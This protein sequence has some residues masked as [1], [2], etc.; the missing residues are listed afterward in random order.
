MADAQAQRS[1]V[2]TGP[3]RSI[4]ATLADLQRRIEIV[5]QKE[6]KVVMFTGIFKSVLAL[7]SIVLG[8]FL[9][10]WVFDLPYFARLFSV[11][12]GVGGISYVVNKHLLRELKK[13]RDD[14]EIA[15]RIEG[16]N[17]DLRGRLISTLQLAR[18]EKHGKYVG[19]PELLEALEDETIKMS[20]PL[21][22]SGIINTD[23][24]KRM[25]VAA[26][27]VLIVKAVLL[28]KFPDYFAALGSRLV[29]ADG[30]FPTKTRIAKIVK[31]QYVARGDDLVVTVELDKE[32]SNEPSDDGTLHF[33]GADNGSKVS[34]AMSR[35]GDKIYS[36][37]L[38][39]P[40]ETMSFVVAIG[41]TRSKSETV[42]VRARPEIDVQKS[43]IQYTLPAYTRAEVPPVDKFGSI[44]VLVGSTA[45]VSIASTKALTSAKIHRADGRDYPLNKL[46]DAGLVWGV[47]NFP[48]DKSNSFHV[49]LVGTD[50]LQNSQPAIEYPIDARPDQ[51]PTIRM[52]KP[53]RDM[54]VIKTAKRSIVFSARDDFNVRT[55]WLC[56]QIT[57]PQLEGQ[58]MSVKPSDIKRYEIPNVPQGKDIREAK[59]TWDL[60][61]LNLNIGETVDFWIEA[62][63]DC[64]SNDFEPVRRNDAEAVAPQAK[65]YPR[66]TDVKLT[67]VTN[68]E[69][70]QEWLAE[71][72]RLSNEIGT[73]KS[74]QEKVGQETIDMLENYEK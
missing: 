50:G 47:D 51:A 73:A 26:A 59:F 66:S 55:L 57:P 72:Q 41:D 53:S 58:S 8:Y 16:R 60:A 65:Y 6:R 12:L 56:Y 39:K 4:M 45:K 7:V 70:H 3:E 33:V 27:I 15:L 21:D 13:I 5:R 61:A 52:M 25:A 22:F 38:T 36:G 29:N 19:S 71:Q 49:S 42:E 54:T 37:T 74:M 23:M 62:D 28:I 24:L 20:A 2:T 67:V 32:L 44:S 17:P 14:D 68:E 31:P 43:S 46:D 10:D 9:I 30:R 63:D 64:A 48:I 69:K 40:S 18:A 11:A 34:V 1:A 35:I